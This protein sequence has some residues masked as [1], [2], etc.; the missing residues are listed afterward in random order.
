MACPSTESPDAD[1]HGLATQPP[2]EHYLRGKELFEH[3]VSNILQRR[4]NSQPPFE[5]LDSLTKIFWA[6]Q[7]ADAKKWWQHTIDQ[8]NMQQC[9]M[10]AVLVF[11]RTYR[12]SVLS[13]IRSL[14]EPATADSGDTTV[15]P[16]ANGAEVDEISAQ[17]EERKGNETWDPMLTVDGIHDADGE[18]IVL[19]RGNEEIDVEA[20]Q[21]DRSDSD[22]A[23]DL[24][25]VKLG[26]SDA[27]GT[28]LPKNATNDCT[29]KPPLPAGRPSKAELWFV[30]LLVPA[31]CEDRGTSIPLSHKAAQ[32]AAREVWQAQSAGQKRKFEAGVL[33]IICRARNPQ[34]SEK[35]KNDMAQCIESY[36]KR[37]T[38]AYTSTMHGEAVSAL[39]VRAFLDKNAPVPDY[40]NEALVNSVVTGMKKRKASYP[41]FKFT[42]W[43]ADG[44][45]LD[46]DPDSQGPHSFGKKCKRMASGKTFVEKLDQMLCSLIRLNRQAFLDIPAD[47]LTMK[48][49]RS[50]PAKRKRK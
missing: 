38:R 8:T 12:P 31:I 4:L 7:T 34:Q 23:V 45:W 14:D 46:F 29:S 21:A 37:A 9:V 47:V 30:E 33:E 5:A 13:Y 27:N 41:Q 28:H 16:V 36:R 44:S 22:D 48:P 24:V 35:S 18:L 15:E 39:F 25:T 17:D 26:S 42:G 3:H 19:D 49:L 1:I 20:S 32:V 6:A 50:R 43:D 40:V 11:M 10:A 2:V